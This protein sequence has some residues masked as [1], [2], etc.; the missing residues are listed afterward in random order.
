MFNDPTI[1]RSSFLYAFTDL[2]AHNDDHLMC[3]C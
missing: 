3:P 2:A 1:S